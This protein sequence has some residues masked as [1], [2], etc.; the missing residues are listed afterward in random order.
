MAG[1]ET[2]ATY[3]PKTEQFTIHSPTIKA[4]KF[5]PGALGLQS[6][7]AVLFARCISL[8][9]DYGVQPFII[10]IRSRETHEPLP[11]IEVGDIGTKLGYNSIDNGYLL[12]KNFKVA[13]NAMLSR[14]A[15]I[16]KEGDFELKTDPRML[17]QIMS[18]TRLHIVMGCAYNLFR[19][20]NIAVR[21][22]V[23]RR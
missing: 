14:F 11:G 20:G 15:E 6:N 1:L 8:E 12:F 3:D 22:A 2:T 5:W 23:C 16:T 18:Q 10:Q 17:Y 13:R 19:S 21:Y 4:A 9:N 7:Y